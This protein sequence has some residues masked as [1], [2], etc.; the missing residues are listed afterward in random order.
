MEVTKVDENTIKVVKD[1]TTTQQNTYSYGD[2]IKQK[3]AIETRKANEIAQRDAEIAEVDVL[4][5]ECIKL[6]IG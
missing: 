6:G 4:I 5:A 2:L 1:I 3:E